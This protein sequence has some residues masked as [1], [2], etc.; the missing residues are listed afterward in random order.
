MC[1]NKWLHVLHLKLL[2]DAY[3][4]FLFYRE[5]VNCLPVLFSIGISLCSVFYIQLYTMTWRFGTVKTYW[6]A[7][8][9]GGMGF[10]FFFTVFAPFEFLHFVLFCHLPPLNLAFFFFI[11]EKQN[12]SC[13]KRL[14]L[15]CNKLWCAPLSIIIEHCQCLNI[16]S[17]ICLE[18]MGGWRQ[19]HCRLYPLVG[20]S[21][22]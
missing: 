20:H 7:F 5:D 22:D 2:C 8:I 12:G 10:N 11:V 6:N 21:M 15:I 3:T 14:W 17:L 4:C 18:F 1:L 19:T 9:S 16:Y 13:R